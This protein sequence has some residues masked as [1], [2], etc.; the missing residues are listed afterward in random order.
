M[1]KNISEDDIRIIDKRGSYSIR[2]GVVW[3]VVAAVL[4][5]GVFFGV[6]TARQARFISELT[7]GRPASVEQ[8][9][10]TAVGKIH[11]VEVNGA[12]VNVTIGRGKLRLLNWAAGLLPDKYSKD[13]HRDLAAAY[14]VFK[15]SVGTQ[16]LKEFEHAAIRVKV[17]YLDGK[18]CKYSF[19][20]SL[21]G[22]SMTV[23]CNYDD[24]VELLDDVVGEAGN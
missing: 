1:S 9:D 15:T 24:L 20:N 2:K 10:A 14:K 17:D 4:L 13:P 6:K 3:G 23:L 18:A 22:Y 7:S 5:L 19:C 11:V 8:V 21:N 16:H 12:K